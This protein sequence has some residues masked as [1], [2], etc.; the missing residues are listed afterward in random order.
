[1]GIFK[2]CD[3]RGVYGKDLTEEI[4]YKIGRAVGTLLA[5]KAVV[6]GGDVR[7]STP[8][9]K[10]EVS[11][12]LVESGAEVL[13]IG[14]VPTPV[15][16]FARRHLGVEPGVMV[17]A[18]HNPPEFNGLKLVLGP[19]PITEDE[20]KAVEE[21]AN[22]GKFRNGSGS[23]RAP[24]I[25]SPYQSFIQS[26]ARAERDA[27]L[28]KVVIDCGNGCN[29]GLAPDLFRRF[30]FHI[31]ELHCTPDGIFPNRNPNSADPQNLVDLI[32]TVR[33]TKADVGVA[34]D[35]DGDRV[36]FVDDRGRFLTSDKAIVILSRYLLAGTPLPVGE[37][38]G[39][40]RRAERV[41][42]DLKCSSVVPES[43]T[44]AGGIPIPER[45]GHTFIKTRMITDDALFGGE[46]SGHFFYR[47]LGGGDDGIY[48]ALLMANM[49]VRTGSKLSELAD[50]V[51][52][53]EN[54]PDIRVP[55]SGNREDVIE[56]IASAFPAEQVSRLDG[57]RIAFKGGWGLARPSVT[58]PAITFRFEA[59]DR[60]RL[61]EIM[62]GF[63]APVPDI[64]RRVRQ[65]WANLRS[66]G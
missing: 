48:S 60:A 43:V 2:A 57:V 21:L 16:Y 13:D 59:E 11:R 64:E 26:I 61:E 14:I 29:S 35:G 23:V 27:H 55:F 9:L 52:A 24:E 42:Y 46:I 30:G 4:V 1:M 15:F 7:I 50:A 62:G 51:P 10:A 44:A 65:A 6:L 22:L 17:T 40:G 53:L 37:G 58:E 56:R 3:V 54:T 31:E 33:S 18:S 32:R 19:L 47:E 12:G 45:S 28:L 36:A 66:E 49:L 20:L 5:G 34:F 63:L 39:G 41:V 25:V 38:A 8:A